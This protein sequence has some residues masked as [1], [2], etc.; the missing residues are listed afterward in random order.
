MGTKAV[1]TIVGGDFSAVDSLLD[2]PDMKI[3]LKMD[4]K[5]VLETKTVDNEVRPAFGEKH[6]FTWD[7]GSRFTLVGMET[8]GILG[9]DKEVFNVSVDAGG[10]LGYK[11]L[12]GTLKNNGNSITVKLDIELPDSPWN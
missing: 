8:G 2:T 7:I 10:I 5:T 6:E 1:L 11:K 3:L 9:S 4:G 12:T